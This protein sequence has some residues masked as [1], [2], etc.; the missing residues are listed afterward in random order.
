MSFVNHYSFLILAVLILG[1]A[2]WRLLRNNPGRREW[3][4]FGALA[5]VVLGGYYT[6]RPASGTQSPAADIQ[7]QIGAGNPVLLEFQ[8]QN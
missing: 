4:L 1:V 8:S 6:F 2:A 3:L 7:A 5:V